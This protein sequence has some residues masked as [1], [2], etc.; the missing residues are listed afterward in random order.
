V[1]TQGW[2]TAEERMTEAV[3]NDVVKEKKFGVDRAVAALSQLAQAAP[4]LEP[5][6]RAELGALFRRTWLTA[7]LHAGVAA[8]YFGYRVWARGADFRTPTLDRTIRDGLGEIEAASQAI[9]D[10]PS[11][12][13]EGT[14]WKWRGDAKRARDYLHKITEEG[15][16]DYTT[17]PF[18]Y[19][20]N[21]V[22]QAVGG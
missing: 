7:R 6:D 4:A 17:E 2:V 10:E 9:I 11:G 8:A 14:E 3:L 15:W 19:G 22:P 20:H 16:P 5:A 1:L 21:A 12:P 18:P 13:A